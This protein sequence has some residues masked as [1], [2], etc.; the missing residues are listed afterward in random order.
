M[1]L[2]KVIVLSVGIYYFLFTSTLA[3]TKCTLRFSLLDYMMD[4]SLVFESATPVT[5]LTLVFPLGLFNGLLMQATV[6][7]VLYKMYYFSS[8]FQVCL[9]VEGK[10]TMILN[11]FFVS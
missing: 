10:G 4:R 7:G 11:T 9:Q 1:L 2:T 8:A 5:D 3:A 6:E